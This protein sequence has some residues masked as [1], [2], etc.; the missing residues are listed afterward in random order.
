[1]TLQNTPDI[2]AKGCSSS[3]E[4]RSELRWDLSPEQIRQRTEKLMQRIKHAYDSV[5]VVDVEKVCYENTL[6]VLAE[7]K[8]DYAGECVSRANTHTHTASCLTADLY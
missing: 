1:M 5:A 6:Q 7:A 2:S 4:N 3:C 8:L